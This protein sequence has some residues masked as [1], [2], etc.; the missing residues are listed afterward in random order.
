MMIMHHHFPK[1]DLSKVTMG[2]SGSCAGLTNGCTEIPFD[3]MMIQLNTMVITNI[4]F[5]DD[6]NDNND[7]K[8]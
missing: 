3:N 7:K 8:G 6:D 4:V 5:K 1:V 2:S